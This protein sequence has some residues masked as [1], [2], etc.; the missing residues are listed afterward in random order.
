MSGNSSVVQKTKL[1]LGTV[2]FGLPY[3]V[4]NTA[5]QVQPETVAAILARA[6]SHGID[7]LD[8]ASLYG[9][10]EA[11]LGEATRLGGGFRIVT[12]T[13]KF[14]DV[15]PGDRSAVSARFDAALAGSLARLRTPSVDG[16]LAH[17]VND[18]LGANG[19]HLWEKMQTAKARG[20]VARVG[21]SIYTGDEIDRLL[22]R[23]RPDIVQVPIN[24]LDQRL[25]RGGQLDKLA[26]AGIEIHARSIFLQGLI[27]Q[28]PAA[29]HP[30]F[31]VLA[32]SLSGI[33][34]A[35]ASAGLTVLEAALAGAAASGRI[36]HMVVGVTSVGELEEIASATKALAKRAVVPDLTGWGCEDER[37]LNPARWNEL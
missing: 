33:R 16:L 32:D 13:A 2:Q 10:S 19:E 3:G 11:V 31:G 15:S 8:T 36:S 27:L 7:L 17:D 35:A 30:K 12:K 25:V 14:G 23:F 20:L 21:A 18:L 28:D 22:E 29:L 5:G 34:G 24:I 37:L 4:T 1:A 6:A 9:S 26:Q